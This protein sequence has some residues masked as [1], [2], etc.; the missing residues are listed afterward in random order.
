M[1]LGRIASRRRSWL[2]QDAKPTGSQWLNGYGGQTTDEL[3][4][5]EGAFRTD[6]IVLAFEQAIAAKAAR[7]G[8]QSLTEPERVVL[9]VEAVER[10][11]NSDGYTGL[12]AT[13]AEHVP[14]LVSSLT[15][16]GSD[17]VAALTESA[18]SELKIRGPLTSAAV[19][20]AMRADAMRDDDELA[21]KLNEYD[22]IYYQTAGD[23]A[24]PLLSFIKK[25]RD[26]ITVP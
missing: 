19:E 3:I 26:Q 1:V 16:I 15:A 8:D 6:S 18:I 13:S 24:D 14:Y 20:A 23:L 9:A 11:V 21:D 17:A 5:L 22:Q 4:A 12:F 2:G 25:N 10:E 7:L